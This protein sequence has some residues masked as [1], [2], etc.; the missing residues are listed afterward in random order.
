MN[1][2]ASTDPVFD[3][4]KDTVIDWDRTEPFIIP[5]WNTGITGY[6][7]QPCSEETKQKI[8]NAKKGKPS[9]T[10]DIPMS[11]EQK[12]K[13]RIAA[14]GKIQSE[15]HKRNISQSLL[16]NKHSEETKRKMSESAKGKPSKTKGKP[17]SE[18][19]KRKIAESQKKRHANRIVQKLI[20]MI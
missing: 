12:E 19:T 6:T 11:E 5:P 4:L 7:T 8:S 20:N 15:E 16:G 1:I 18:E 13:C 9:K 10:K 17:R 2:Y 3:S 14:T